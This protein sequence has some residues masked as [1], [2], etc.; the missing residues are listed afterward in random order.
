MAAPMGTGKGPLA[1]TS[2]HMFIAATQL[3]GRNEPNV[4][5][6][7]DFSAIERI[8]A[9]T[10]ATMWMSLQNIIVSQISQI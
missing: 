2:T 8:K 4:H 10:C 5:T 3:K 7:E 6:T 1:D 9:P